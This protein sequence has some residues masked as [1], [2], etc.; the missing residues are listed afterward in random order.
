[1][2]RRLFD[3]V[4]ELS[5]LNRNTRHFAHGVLDPGSRLRYHQ[6][7]QHDPCRDLHLHHVLRLPRF[8]SYR[9]QVGHHQPEHSQGSLEDS[10]PDLRRRADLLHGGVSADYRSIYVERHTK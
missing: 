10:S 4:F 6:H 7:K 3:F 5:G 8:T 1:M 2:V 9:F